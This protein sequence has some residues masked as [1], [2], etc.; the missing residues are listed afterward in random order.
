MKIVLFN[1]F[2]QNLYLNRIQKQYINSYFCW[3]IYIY[4]YI[5]YSIHHMNCMCRTQRE[6]STNFFSIFYIIVELSFIFAN[7]IVNEKIRRKREENCY[8]FI[9]TIRKWEQIVYFW[10]KNLSWRFIEIIYI[11]IFFLKINFKQFIIRAH[12][13]LYILFVYDKSTIILYI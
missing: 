9:S 13:I 5:V 3:H 6:Y 2:T 8:P 10:L 1:S 12:S 11:C 7:L 4:A